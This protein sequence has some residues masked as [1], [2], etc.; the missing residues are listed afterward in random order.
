MKR[1]VEIG[2]TKPERFHARYYDRAGRL[3]YAMGLFFLGGG[4][5][6]F[7][8]TLAALFTAKPRRWLPWMLAAMLVGGAGAGYVFWTV[9]VLDF[10]TG[11]L[12]GGG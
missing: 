8:G 9:P 3:G 7:L 10:E 6:L 2:W 5:A 11:R 1:D 4:A 12:L